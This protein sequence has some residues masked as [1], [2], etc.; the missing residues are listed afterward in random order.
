MIAGLTADPLLPSAWLWAAGALALF[1]AALAFAQRRRGAWLRALAAAAV[2]AALWNPVLTLS[3]REAAPRTAVVVVDASGSMALAGRRAQAEAA[4]A[5]LADRLRAAGFNV[6]R[7]AA[8]GAERTRLFAALEGALAGRPRAEIAGAVLVTDGQA[9]DAPADRYPFPV[10]GLVVGA[11][12]A[13][14]VGVRLVEAP[15]SAPAG[16]PLRLRIALDGAEGPLPVILSVDGRPVL[17]VT[18]AAE[19][20]TD[21]VLPSLAAGEHW[22]EAAVQPPAGDLSRANDRAF[23]RVTGVRPPLRV[24]LVTGAP[25]PGVRVWRTFLKSDPSVELV[26]F[27][28]LRTFASEDPASPD[29]LAL[30]EFP[31]RELFIERIDQ[32]ELIVFDRFAEPRAL[33]AP[34][35]AAVADRVR[36]GG[37]LLVVLGPEAGED[38]GLLAGPLASVLP[39]AATGAAREGAFRPA[40]T[41]IGRRHPAT[42]ALAGEAD[43]WGAWLRYAPLRTRGG[44]AVVMSGPGA[45]PLLTLARVG[46]GRSA[47]LASDQSWLWARGFEGG[48][49]HGELLRRTAFWLMKEPELEEERLWA[50]ADGA[51]LVVRRR[52]LADS[53]EPVVATAPSG[54]EQT[55][56]L[57]PVAPGLLEAA[58]SAEEPGLWRVRQGER[59]AAAAM[60]GPRTLE[61]RVLA[62]TDAVLAPVARRSRGAVRWLAEGGVPQVRAVERGALAG[63]DWL[64]F[65][66]RTVWRTT[67]ERR[68]P[69]L[70]PLLLA[71]ALAAVMLLA[72]WREGR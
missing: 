67:G 41:E 45:A 42:A 11:R 57:A 27:T 63:R 33:P 5:A 38:R 65:Q 68:A 20:A 31:T 61:S 25:Y 54:A 14:D 8:G 13:R 35:L 50:A 51:R 2:W 3:E 15:P 70:P 59:T 23:A 62:S 46:Q 60:G 9:H 49:P 21:A 53:A 71:A 36:R 17:T 69:L 44:D 56:A 72:W 39:V 26:H 10:H 7:A 19:G 37:A 12:E 16:E 55:V 22:M 32:F 18:A 58:L 24:L 64:G 40:L 34:Y 29:E 43:R 66:S 4:G 30:I 52:T 47:V 6:V 48:G 1:A 28:I